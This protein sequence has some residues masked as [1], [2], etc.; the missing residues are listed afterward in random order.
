MASPHLSLLASALVL[1]LLAGPWCAGCGS[2]SGTEAPSEEEARAAEPVVGADMATA[3]NGFGL[4]LYKELAKHDAAKNVFVSPASIELALAMTYNGAGGET[5]TAMAKALGLEKMTLDEANKANADLLALLK[6]VDPKVELDIA[7]SLWGRQGVEFDEGFVKRNT[8]AYGADVRSVDFRQKAS[9]D[10]IN[11]WVKEKTKGK[12]DQL[13]DHGAI[14]DALLVLVN[15][16]YFKGTWSLPFNKDETQDGPF[17]PIA[18]QAVTLPMMR[19]TGKFAYLETDALQAI[20]LPYGAKRM[21]ATILLPRAN[22]KFGEFVAGLKPDTLKALL[23]EMAARRGTIVLPRFKTDYST[24]L[25][26]T[27]QA[28]GMSV[29]FTPAADF[30]GMVKPAAAE[31]LGGKPL[32][33]DVIH[34]TALEV[35]EEGTVAA[36]A[37]GVIVG[38]TAMPVDKPF[39]MTVDHPFVLILRDTK[40]GVILFI[41]SIVNPK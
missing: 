2:S 21:A 14:R 8:A 23:D 41:G 5:K 37:T 11:G 27:L 33:T 6:G 30:G 35:N 31:T 34:K 10:A 16:L 22:A 26:S 9:A 29:A 17:T 20:T 3:V 18:G 25:K 19:E 24:S 38:V 13:V 32:L 15:A 39:T 28:L 12:I 36:A 7:N 4:K 40:T 1:G